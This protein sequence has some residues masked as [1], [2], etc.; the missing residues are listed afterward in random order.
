MV[1]PPRVVFVFGNHK[2]VFIL[3]GENH[4]A[5][6]LDGERRPVKSKRVDI[7]DYFDGVEVTESEGETVNLE[8]IL[9][10][11]DLGSKP[12]IREN[13]IELSALDQWGHS[14]KTIDVALVV[15]EKGAIEISEKT[16]DKDDGY[17]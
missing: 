6:V 5:A 3:I 4:Y 15:N 1:N 2:L 10:C 11:L 17:Y 13:G 8:Y 7:S 14:S 9:R 16:D 12:T